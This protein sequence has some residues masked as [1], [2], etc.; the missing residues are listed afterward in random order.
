MEEST[1]PD[2]DISLMRLSKDLDELL[3]IISRFQT[4]I[5]SHLNDFITSNMAQKTLVERK[6]L[7]EFLASESENKKEF[8]RCC[9]FYNNLE[10]QQ[11]CHPLCKQRVAKQQKRTNSFLS[12]KKEHEVIRLAS[13][14]KDLTDENKCKKVRFRYYT[15]W[16]LHSTT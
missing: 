3:R 6:D 7:Q 13:L 1:T 12:S 14:L 15:I 4:L 11:Q 8:W 9:Y 5:Q 16:L 10:S 2:S